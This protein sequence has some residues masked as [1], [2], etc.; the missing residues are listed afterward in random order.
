MR[1]YGKITYKTDVVI[2]MSPKNPKM[3]NKNIVSIIDYKTGSPDID[4]NN[5]IYGIGMQLPIYLYL[6]KHSNLENIEIAGFYLQKI[7]HNKLRYQ[8]DKDYKSELEKLYRLEGYSNDNIDIL[9]KF[10]KNYSDSYMIK[11]MKTSSKGFYA[12]TKVLNEKQIDNLI[13]IVEEKID[14]ASSNIINSNFD[15]NPK[16]IGLNMVGCEFCKFKDICYK[17]EEDIV[18]LKEQNYKDFLGGEDNAEL[19]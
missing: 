9:S 16:K 1:Y 7:I 19:D 8:E 17:K 15:I 3:Y 12:Y 13:N 2:H 6:A 5:T 10:D 4:I 11:G 18:N 14:E